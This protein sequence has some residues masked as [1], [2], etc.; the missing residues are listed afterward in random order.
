MSK[1][2][3]IELRRIAERKAFRLTLTD[4]ARK[5]MEL[6]KQQSPETLESCRN[7]FKQETMIEGRAYDTIHQTAYALFHGRKT[8]EMIDLM[9]RMFELVEEDLDRDAG[10]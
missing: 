7:S 2:S 6:L 1:F 3:E 8:G 9:A 10:R 5:L 4:D